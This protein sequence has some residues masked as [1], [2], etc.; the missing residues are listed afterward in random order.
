ME[1]IDLPSAKIVENFAFDGCDELIYVEFGKNLESIG[2]TAFCNCA[3]KWITIP[4]KGD[5]FTHD[6]VFA[7]CDD[8]H[9]VRLIGEALQETVDAFICDDWKN[10]M[11]QEIDSIKQILPKVDPGDLNFG[12][13]GDITMAIRDWIE[14][15][16]QKIIHYKVEHYRLLSLAS[17]S[18]AHDLPNE[19]VIGNIFSFLQLPGY[20]FEGEGQNSANARF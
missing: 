6:D 12:E 1:S 14:R 3:L 20:E 9:R 8:F 7:G 17:A 5:L 16:R 19:I 15:V 4:L 11:N 2:Q 10:D 18:L 13:E